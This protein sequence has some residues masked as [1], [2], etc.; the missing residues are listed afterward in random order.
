[1][2]IVNSKNDKELI[3]HCKK[4]TQDSRNVWNWLKNGFDSKYEDCEKIPTFE[5]NQYLYDTKTGK[6]YKAEKY[7]KDLLKKY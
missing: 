4:A 2:K 5:I 1:M 6:L 7:F 3:K